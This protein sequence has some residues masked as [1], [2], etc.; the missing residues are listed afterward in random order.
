MPAQSTSG[1]TQTRRDISVAKEFKQPLSSI[2]SLTASP[3]NGRLH[4]PSTSTPR[5]I[6]G[7]HNGGRCRGRV[8]PTKKAARV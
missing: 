6:T 1:N 4:S 8:S 7:R 2:K 5:A 3:M